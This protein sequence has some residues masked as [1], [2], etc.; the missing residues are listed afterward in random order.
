[1]YLWTMEQGIESVAS[2]TP[3]TDRSRIRILKGCQ[4]NSATLSGSKY[5]CFSDPGVS[6]LST[7]GYYLAALWA[8]FGLISECDYLTH[9][10][11]RSFL[12][13]IGLKRQRR[14]C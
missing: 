3:G 13:L 2:N 12:C 1:M 11:F 9:E 5:N 6:L 4:P 10:T 8:A 7:P 14:E